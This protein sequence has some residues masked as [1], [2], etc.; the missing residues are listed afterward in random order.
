MGFVAL[1]SLIY[2]SM[3]LYYVRANAARRAGKEDYKI[4]GKTEDEIAA[5][6]DD[7]PRFVYAT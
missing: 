5:M 2:G 4:E 3:F 7:S 1:G 6:G